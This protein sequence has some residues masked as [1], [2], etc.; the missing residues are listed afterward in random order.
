MSIDQR[1]LDKAV[2]TFLSGPHKDVCDLMQA[3]IEAY[4]AAKLPPTLWQSLDGYD[5]ENDDG[6]WILVH[7]DQRM[8]GS[9]DLMFWDD[10]FEWC[11]AGE[12]KTS[13]SGIKAHG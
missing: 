7:R 1:A 12:G 8:P 4:E 11:V 6:N 2:E 13:L 10:T 9:Y 5:R 3:A